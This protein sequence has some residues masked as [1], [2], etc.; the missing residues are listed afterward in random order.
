MPTVTCHYP[1]ATHG[2]IEESGDNASVRGPVDVATPIQ[3][4]SNRLHSY[5]L[6]LNKVFPTRSAFACAEAHALS[7]V[8]TRLTPGNVDWEKFQFSPASSDGGYLLWKPCGNC[9]EW[10]SPIWGGSRYRLSE[11][12]LQ[13]IKGPAQPAAPL[14]INDPGQF[15][16]LGAKVKK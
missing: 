6:G 1:D 9:C 15:P 10:L 16:A 13:Q 14:N 11:A 7:L 2:N 12:A 3:L 4:A 8:L 5:M